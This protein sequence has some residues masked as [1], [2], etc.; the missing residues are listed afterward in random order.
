MFGPR[1][2][3]SAVGLPQAPLDEIFAEPARRFVE[4]RGG[5]VIAKSSARVEMDAQGEI[6]AVRAGADL[7]ET[8]R[9]VST[10]PWHA[11][12]R[13]WAADPPAAL[14]AVLRDAAAMRSSPIVSVNIWL[15]GGVDLDTFVGLVGGPMHWVFPK[16]GHLAL[17]SSGA[18][19]LVD[20]ENGEIT[21]IAVDQLQRSLPAL[22]KKNVLRS[23][24]VR[25]HRATFSVAPG[26]PPRPGSV[27]PVPGFYRRR[28]DYTA[29]P[30]RSKAPCSAATAPPASSWRDN[31]PVFSV[32]VHYAELALKGRN[33]PW[34]LHMLVRNIRDAL[35]DLDLIQVR[36]LMG[37]IEAR[38]GP[39][40][41]WNE[42]Q[43]RLRLIPGIG[44]FSRATHVAPDL[45]AIA[46]AC[47]EA[48]KGR[49]ARSF[50]I[51]ARRAD[52]RFPVPS[53][54]I[55]RYVGR[56][57]QAATG[58]PVDLDHPD[59]VVRVELVTA[60]AFFFFD[61]LPGAGGLPVG[62]SGRVMCLLSGGI[63]SPVAA[64]RMIRRGAGPAV[65]P[66]APILSPRRGQGARSSSLAGTLRSSCS[67]CRS[68]PS[69][70]GRR[71]RAAAAARDRVPGD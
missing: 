59:V 25:E 51:A 43:A 41:D 3:D 6:S 60:D 54:E 8:S 53:P 35:A 31:H 5:R 55:E 57:V 15:E 11:I 1:P 39:S 56:A 38:M 12:A 63:D 13:I 45:D 9:V 29:S 2:Q 62:T 42:V 28:L 34:F 50:R 44:N 46:R 26:G 68:R 47:A 19:D 61:K 4:T 48:V 14:A 66:P 58:W 10:V 18:T 27:T 65:R 7:I 67:W 69:S 24:V 71:H 22:G 40:A 36:P 23:V 49:T 70:E 64:W 52:K 21:R 30:A 20:L 32:I 37:R 17:V 33:R 16:A